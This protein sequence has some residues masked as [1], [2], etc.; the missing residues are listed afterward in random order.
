MH[1]KLNQILQWNS[2]SLFAN[3]IELVQLLDEH[4]ISVAAISETWLKPS[5][6]F[7]IPGYHCLRHDR[8]DGKGGTALII[9]NSIPFKQIIFHTLSNNFQIVAAVV[10][11]I[12][13]LSIYIPP[14]TIFV[15]NEWSTFISQIRP[16][17]MLLGDFNAHSP[18]WGSEITNRSGRNLLYFMDTYNLCILNDGSPT[19]FTAPQQRK[20]AVDLSLCSSSVI[21][22]CSWNILKDPLSSDH[23]PIMITFHHP[24]TSHSISIN[25]SFKFQTKDANWRNFSLELDSI[26][27]SSKSSLVNISLQCELFPN[28]VIKAAEKTLKKRNVNIKIKHSTPWWDEECTGVINSRKEAISIFRKCM[29][30]E[31]YLSVKRAQA[32]AK[33][34]L[35]NKKRSGWRK[36]CE[37]L[38]PESPQSSVWSNLKKFASSY[39]PQRSKHI[40]EEIIM[41][42]ADKIAPPTVARCEEMPSFI[43]Y[44]SH[45]SWLDSPFSVS[46]LKR[47][48]NSLSDSSPGPDGILYSFIK[49]FSDMSVEYFLSLIN[50]MF[51]TGF[52]P[53]DWKVQKIVPILKPGKNPSE[54]SSYRPIALSS[55]L[56]KVAEHL[57]KNR[58]EWFVE[59]HRIISPNQYGFRKKKSTMDNLSM[60]TTD[61]RIS[62]SLNSYTLATF[63]D[64]SSAYD[65]VLINVLK[66]KLIKIKIPLKLVQFIINLLTERS[67]I[68][69]F[70]SKTINRKLWKG[71]PQGSVI[72]PLLFNIY[73]SDLDIVIPSSIKRLY[74][75]DDFLIYISHKNLSHAAKEL[76][77]A[78]HNIKVWLLTNGMN[79]ATS[80]TK[81][82]AFTRK[83]KIPPFSVSFDNVPLQIVKQI[84]F[85]GLLLDHKLSWLPHIQNISAK[86]EKGLN[87]MRAVSRVWW[88]SHPTTLKLMYSALVRSHLDYGT[89]LFDP[90]PKYLNKKLERIQSKAL[91]L[92]IGAMKS[93][94][95]NSLQV[96]C[97]EPPLILR[98]QF[99][100]DKYILKS[101]SIS[102]HSLEQSLDHLFNNLIN[103]KRLT[104]ENRFPLLLKSFLSFKSLSS[105]LQNLQKD[106][107]L[108]IFTIPFDSINFIPNIITSEFRTNIL[109]SSNQ[110]AEEN[111]KN[112]TSSKFPG[113]S[114]IYTDGSKSDNKDCGAAVHIPEF[115]LN[116]SYKLPKEISIFTA[117]CFAIEQALIQ[118]QILN[119]RRALLCTD[120]LSA[121]LKISSNIIHCPEDYIICNIKNIL[122]S[123]NESKFETI[124][125]WVPGHLGIEGNEKAD[126]LAKLGTI[127]GSNPFDFR[128]PISDVFPILKSNMI[129]SWEGNWANTKTLTGAFYAGIQNHIP[130]K[131]WF[132]GKKKSK[133]FISC[134]SRMRIGHCSI[135]SHLFKIRVLDSPLCQCGVENETLDHVFFNCKNHSSF[136]GI[137]RLLIKITHQSPLSIPYLLSLNNSRVY[138]VLYKFID[139]NDFNI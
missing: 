97:A 29:T 7:K 13:I 34:V 107:I 81:V 20:S 136:K 71:L 48:I 8:P 53:E 18:S 68:I 22:K 16:P 123:L 45:S 98:R 28:M 115:N 9:H 89:F 137:Y 32:E 47:V 11:D 91:R 104:D 119:I 30:F 106:P 58:L 3:K 122:K 108:P 80:K 84:K 139:L 70:S 64:L 6:Q 41:G 110:N 44:P 78:L 74:F 1:P 76:N 132:H 55:C 31:N 36:F 42:F 88:G 129:R 99:L 4:N 37:N 128:I 77:L 56:M 112:I 113:F 102:R 111:F 138:S 43:S 121:V 35:K 54:I 120:S 62:Q 23:F 72:S 63:L 96:E 101:F 59:N 82:V 133:R 19:R 118:I 114:L 116:L 38:S 103:N 52:I 50:Y 26:V 39:T 2:R 60:L 95:I 17:Y 73:I 57:I 15:E 33:R 90:L 10:S 46:E 92:I 14:S 12:T 105:S 61:I 5:Y 130:N 66:K 124:L 87:M 24:T 125:V 117:E 65:D 40:P 67:I 25:N 134:I 86:C 100:A 83:R 21:T 75:A 85:L 131:P 126:S 94:P 49:A 135:A 69:H 127:S 79:L 27:Q 51:E 109:T 93:S